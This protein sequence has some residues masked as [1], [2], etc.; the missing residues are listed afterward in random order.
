MKWMTRQPLLV[1]LVLYFT[2]VDAAGATFQ[3]AMLHLIS[4]QAFSGRQ[5]SI[6]D[7]PNEIAGFLLGPAFAIRLLHGHLAKPLG[8]RRSPAIACPARVRY[9]STL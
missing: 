1:W 9:W 6:V 4:L 5:T 3:N 7:F 8:F 2:R